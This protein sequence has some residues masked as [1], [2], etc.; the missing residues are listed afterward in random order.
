MTKKHRFPK[1]HYVGLNVAFTLCLEDR[2][3]FFVKAE[4]VEPFVLE[5]RSASEKYDCPCIY[6]FM[7]DHLHVV[8]MS[9]SETG[10]PLRAIEYFKQTTGYWFKRNAIPVS[11]Q[12]SFYDEIIRSSRELKHQV[13]YIVNNPVR[14]GLVVDWDAYPFTGAIGCDLHQLLSDVSCA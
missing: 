13:Y 4:R 2:T 6:C 1:D 12:G 11:W 14:R 8:L 5:L 7:P 10:Q 9:K 3:P